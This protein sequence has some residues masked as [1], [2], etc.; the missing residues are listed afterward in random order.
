MKSTDPTR[1]STR[2]ALLAALGGLALIVA[3][4][5]ADPS[6]DPDQQVLARIGDES[7]T[8]G[9]FQR[10][11]EERSRRRPGFFDS[12]SNREALLDEM[13][14]WRAMLAEARASGVLED[15]EFRRLME[16]M[17]V[18]QLRQDRL[19]EALAADVV[20]DEA[21]A[22][23][24]EANRDEFSRPERRRIALIRVERSGRSEDA[25]QARMRIEEARQAALELPADERAFG[26]VAVEYSADRSSR[27]QGGVIGWLVDHPERRYRWDE[28]VLDAAFALEEAGDISPVI[29]SRSGYSLVR[30]VELEPGT[31]RPLEQVADGIRH[32]LRKER[33]RDHEATLVE[34][35][36][37]R[38]T[39]EVDHDLLAAIVPPAV[40]P[41]PREA[42][43]TDRR[44]PPLPGDTP[45]DDDTTHSD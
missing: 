19:D 35:V 39:V 31:T 15:P 45:S 40:V 34:R 28:E 17:I 18:R 2:L 6:A 3:G 16:R 4:C 5:G 11:L 36:L 1:H 29:T 24:Y 32:R 22:S 23:Y 43:E 7:I 14:G 30:L 21:I 38:H 20:S 37:E 13:V 27:Y 42:P 12:E 9:E 41:P 33:V 10:E 25:E 26:A 44:P 8:V